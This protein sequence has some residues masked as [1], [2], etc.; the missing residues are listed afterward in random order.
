ML[1]LM[2]WKIRVLLF[3]TAV[4]LAAVANIA[5]IRILQR[6]QE[7]AFDTRPS[8]NAKK[9]FLPYCGYWNIAPLKSWARG[10]LVVGVFS[11]F[12]VAALLISCALTLPK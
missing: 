7:L 11:L 6:M 10:P 8:W 9:Q 4:A 1:C 5:A 12:P 2:D 3:L